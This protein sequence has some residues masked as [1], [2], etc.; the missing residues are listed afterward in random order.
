MMW[1][2]PNQFVE[3]DFDFGI[4]FFDEIYCL[5]RNLS[6]LELISLTIINNDEIKGW[7][8]CINLFTLN[9]NVKK[10][11]KKRPIKIV[12]N[13]NKNHQQWINEFK[14]KTKDNKN[15]MKTAHSEL[16]QNKE[17]LTINIIIDSSVFGVLVENRIFII[18][19]NIWLSV[20]RGRKKKHINIWVRNKPNAINSTDLLNIWIN[21][22]FWK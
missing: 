6:L 8:T 17:T 11:W 12:I 2:K 16:T 13:I 9:F 10:Q 19:K 22:N 1:K 5:S 18:K 20:I 4:D 21:N 14:N 15:S 7:K 3:L